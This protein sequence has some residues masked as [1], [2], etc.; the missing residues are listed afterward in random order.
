MPTPLPSRATVH[1]PPPGTTRASLDRRGLRL[2][3]G[4]AAV[5][6]LLPVL[7]EAQLRA[8]PMLGYNT[9]REVAVWVQTTDAAEVRL[10]YWPLDDVRD[11]RHSE[12]ARTDARGAF[13]AT[14]VAD[15]LDEGTGYEYQVLLDGEAMR[16][17]A[18][19]RFAT[20]PLWDF[21]TDPPE[22]TFAL[23]SCYY[24][25]EPAYDRPGRPYGGEYGVFGV[26]D[27]VGPDLMLWLG[28]NIYLRPGDFQSRGAILHRYSHSRAVP[29]LQPL[30]RSAH[31]YAT[32]DDHDYGPNDSDRAY[33]Y[34]HLTREAFDLFWANPPSAHPALAPGIGTAFRYGDA[35]FFVLDDRTFRAPNNCRTCE[36]KPYFG[37]AQVDWLV[38][39]LAGS[40]AAFKFVMTGGQILNSA[41]VYETYAANH[42]EERERLLDRLAE[43]GVRNVVFL[44]GDRHH[45]ELSRLERGGVVLYDF[46]ASPLT[47]GVN[48]R[49]EDEPNEHRVPGTWAAARGF[50]T[51]TLTGPRL[52]RTATLRLYDNT[53]AV[54]WERIIAMQPP[55]PRD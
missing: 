8:G 44:T 26:I 43:E 21:R 24:A 29:E 45:S 30:L 3:L 38:D 7:A 1:A 51:V 6:T 46:T 23:G 39:Q 13:C 55:P 25:N 28:D 11:V 18:P 53:G 41:E 10:R 4:V 27:S 15:S 16:T 49:S 40:R 5:A 32:W 20:Q 50:G 47:S 19:L 33:V 22:I 2:A 35:E 54:L 48:T 9:M 12:P 52:E 36:P 37:E 34:R 31:H 42:A 14:L 17:G